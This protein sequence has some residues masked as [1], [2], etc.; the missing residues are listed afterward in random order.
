M[1]NESFIIN[2]LYKIINGIAKKAESLKGRKIS[3][4]IMVSYLLF[5]CVIC[6]FHEPWYDEAEAWNIAANGSLLEL[7]FDI[8]H[9]EGHPSLWHIILLPFARS[10][11]GYEVSLCI[12]SLLFSGLSVYLI[13]FKSPFPTIV[14]LLLPFSFFVFY[15][16]GI[17]ARPYCVTMLGLLIIACIYKDRHN[18]PFLYTVSLAFL[19][20]TSAYGITIS[21]GLAI[22]LMIEALRKE[23]VKSFIKSRSLISLTLLLIYAV[24]IIVRIIPTA[25]GGISGY[26]TDA[27]NS[28]GERLI[29]TFFA[30]LPDVFFT[31]TYN[32]YDYLHKIPLDI[33]WLLIT[34]VIGAVMLTGIVIIARKQKTLLPFIFPYVFFT[35]FGGF[36]YLCIHHTGILFCFVLF[37]AWI[38]MEAYRNTE[39][40]DVKGNKSQQDVGLSRK[41]LV[42]ICACGIVVSVWWNIFSCITEIKEDYAPAKRLSEYIDENGLSDA[43]ILFGWSNKGTDF[44]HSSV[45]VEFI[46]FLEN[47]EILNWQVEKPLFPG[48]LTG[49]T[50][51]FMQ[52]A[53]E[54]IRN[55]PVPD[56]II[57]SPDL[58][59]LYGDKVKISDY[60]QVCTLKTGHIW[61]GIRTTKD[62]YVYVRK[63]LKG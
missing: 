27:V 14:R 32:T 61:K 62:T 25:S 3:I 6:F 17:I 50:S 51:E 8:P 4:A 39:K 45:M 23:G 52:E 56:M 30:M 42:I 10:G 26:T 53:A 46:P 57:D 12:I 54:R 36:V 49:E 9:L 38:T 33:L 29:Y 59:F 60:E 37:W 1:K 48:Y 11:L 21:G 63:N 20:A 35:G 5:H 7:I 58:Q 43:K 47:E 24:F 13:L 31:N 18:K 16:Y 44:K 55:G 40:S 22:A 15:Q 2:K 41:L 28:M 19:C 34:A